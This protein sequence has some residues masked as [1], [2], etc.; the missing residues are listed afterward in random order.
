MDTIMPEKA[1]PLT[2]GI[3]LGCTLMDSSCYI[4]TP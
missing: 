1:C 2:C 4:H 3:I